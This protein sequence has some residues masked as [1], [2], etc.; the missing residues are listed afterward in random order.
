MIKDKVAKLERADI[1]EK[2]QNA[3]EV[4]SRDDAGPREHA[5]LKLLEQEAVAHKLRA[6]HPPKP[7]AGDSVD[8]KLD[9]AL[10]DSF[11]SSDP[12]SFVQAAPITRHDEALSTVCVAVKAK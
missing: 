6:L 1:K 5:D 9:K 10:E 12:V 2:V 8:A 4:A 11:P 3:R 7:A